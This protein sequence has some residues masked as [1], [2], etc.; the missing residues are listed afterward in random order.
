MVVHGIG[1]R[2]GFDIAL[3]SE[4]YGLLHEWGLPTARHNKVVG[5]LDEVREFIAYFGENRHSVEHEIDGVVVKLDEIPL[6]GTAGLHRAPRAGPSPGS[7]RR[8]RSTPSCSTSRSASAGPGASRRT[9]RW[10]R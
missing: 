3:L 9:R 1:A 5:S 10:S 7:T 4:A 2:E 6:Q 8:R